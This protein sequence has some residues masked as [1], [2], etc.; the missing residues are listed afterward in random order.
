MRRLI[1][2]AWTLI[3]ASQI[4][5]AQSQELILPIVVNGYVKQPIHFQTIFR[6]VNLSSTITQVTLEA[7]QNDGTPVRLLELF[8]I[9][10]PGTKT[11]LKIDA[12]GSAEVF[13]AEDVPSF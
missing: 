1:L 6:I 13:T 5:S 4:A 8:P 9:P 12:L 11:V 10:R 3:A 7:Y 2:V